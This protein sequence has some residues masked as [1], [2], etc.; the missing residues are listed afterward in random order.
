MDAKSNDVAR[1]FM[2]YPFPNVR[3]KCLLCERSNC[4]RWKGYYVR[5]WV[6]SVTG[7]SGSIAI[8]VGHCKSNKCDYSYFP[9][10]LIP[11]RRMSRASLFEYIKT[12]QN[13]GS[14]K[15]CIDELIG[16]IDL[17][18]FTMALS[19]AYDLIYASVRA[20]RLN[21]ENLAILPPF[22]TSVTVFRNLPRVVTQNLFQLVT[23]PWHGVH[24]I[25]FHPP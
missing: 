21:H 15:K 12:F 22:L 4:A 25:I 20:L 18:D 10:F 23:G 16:G 17:P 24:D 1:A 6:C 9:D 11:G 3:L 8:H 2:A 5:Q 14:V 7:N 13:T 19:S